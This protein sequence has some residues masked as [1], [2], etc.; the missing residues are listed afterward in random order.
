LMCCIFRSRSWSSL[1][2]YIY[3]L[4]LLTLKNS[5]LILIPPS[6]V[7]ETSL[8]KKDFLKKSCFYFTRFAKH[9]RHK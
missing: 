4:G 3:S 7:Q 2:V 8:L 6:E 5:I 1:K 9:N